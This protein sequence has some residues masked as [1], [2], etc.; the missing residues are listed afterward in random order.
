MKVAFVFMSMPVGGAEDFA[1]TVSRQPRFAGRTS[2]QFLCLRD[3]GILGEAFAREGGAIETLGVSRSRRFSLPGVFRLARWF[4]QQ[5]IDVVHSQTYHAHTYAV[6]AAR[7]AGIPVVLH[8]QK[9]L[10]KMKWRRGLTFRWLARAADGIIALSSQT[11]EAFHQTFQIPHDRLH[12]LPNLVDGQVFAPIEAEKRLALRQRLGLPTDRFLIGTVASLNAV[13]NHPATLAVAKHLRDAGL[14]VSFWIFGEGKDRPA[15]EAR[16][17]KENLADTVQ[18]AGNHR[19]IHPWVQALDLFVLPSHWEGQSLALLQAVSC[20]IPVL[21]S[22]IE[23]NLAVLGGEHPGLFAPED[24]SRYVKLAQRAIELPEFRERL[25]AS[26]KTIAL[27]YA[28][29]VA[30]Q[31]DGIYSQVLQRRKRS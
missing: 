5:G 10:E 28:T 14:P 3:A 2:F 26:Q 20:E 31:L 18:L 16:I 13:K 4:R 8:Q 1:I 29:E 12:V 30:V 27:P 19:P 21:A 22:S 7:M 17:A 24:H 11:A 9:T 25:L 15:L 23:G 6:P